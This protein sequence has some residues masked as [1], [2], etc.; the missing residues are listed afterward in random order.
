MQATGDIL[1]GWLRGFGPD[2]PAGDYYVRQLHDWKG[3]ADVE[4]MSPSVLADYGLSCGEAV[5]RAHARSGDR[6]AIAAYLGNGDAVIGAFVRFA[7]VYA[8]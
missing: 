2:G 3:S 8:D 4:S 5:A 1:L 6:I 7:E